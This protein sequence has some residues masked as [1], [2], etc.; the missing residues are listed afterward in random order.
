M[1]RYAHR[2][3][4]APTDSCAVERAMGTFMDSDGDIV[5]LIVSLATAPTFTA[6]Q[7]D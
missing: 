2:R 3:A 5:E 4:V 6:G 1:Y 7:G